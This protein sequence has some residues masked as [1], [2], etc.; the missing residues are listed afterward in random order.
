MDK[1]IK[2]RLYFGRCIQDGDNQPIYIHDSDFSQFLRSHV[3]K[4]F[5]AYTVIDARG[6][7]K[8][9]HEPTSIIEILVPVS[10]S[11]ENLKK[12]ETTKVLKIIKEYNR[13]FSQDCVMIEKT[14]VDVAFV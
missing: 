13:I 10:E 4:H 5:E 14:V 12:T 1:Y 2:Y 9:E 8:G 6:T 3:D 7:W 11:S